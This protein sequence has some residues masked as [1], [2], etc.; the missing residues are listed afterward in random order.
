M[1]V[2]IVKG[3]WYYESSYILGLFKHKDKA[4]AY[5]KETIEPKDIYDYI[6]VAEYEVEE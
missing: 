2:Y 3:G 6:T 4:D 1:K 5:V